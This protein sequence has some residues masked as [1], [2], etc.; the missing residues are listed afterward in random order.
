MAVIHFNYTAPE[1][2]E[3]E[4]KMSFSALS[5]GFSAGTTLGCTTA[6]SNDVNIGILNLSLKMEGG[7]GVGYGTEFKSLSVAKGKS[8]L[9][10][11][12]KLFNATKNL[13]QQ[14]QKI[15]SMISSNEIEVETAHSTDLV[16]KNSLIFTYGRDLIIENT[17][18]ELDSNKILLA[19]S[20]INMALA[21]GVVTFALA[22]NIIEESRMSKLNENLS[23]GS[24]DENT[25]GKSSGSTESVTVIVP[26]SM[27][28]FTSKNKIAY[29]ITE[30]SLNISDAKVTIYEIPKDSA[31]VSGQSS[32]NYSSE[33]KYAVFSYKLSFTVDIDDQTYACK[34]CEMTE[35]LTVDNDPDDETKLIYDFSDLTY[36][37]VNKPITVKSSAGVAKSLSGRLP[38]LMIAEE[39]ENKK[40]HLRQFSGP[41]CSHI[42][43]MIRSS[44][45]TKKFNDL[46]FILDSDTQIKDENIPGQYSLTLSSDKFVSLKIDKF[47]DTNIDASLS[48]PGFKSY[49]LNG[50]DFVLCEGAMVN[51]EER[52]SNDQKQSGKETLQIGSS[53]QFV[54]REI[55]RNELSAVSND[56]D[57]GT[58][59]KI[60]GEDNKIL[61]KYAEDDAET[62]FY[63]MQFENGVIRSSSHGMSYNLNARILVSIGYNENENDKKPYILQALIDDNQDND[64]EG[65]DADSFDKAKSKK[66]IISKNGSMAVSRATVYERAGLTYNASSLDQLLNRTFVIYANNSAKGVS[67]FEPLTYVYFFFRI[68]YDEI[69]DQLII[70][71]LPIVNYA[72]FYEAMSSVQS[73]PDLSKLVKP[74]KRT[75]LNIAMGANAA[76]PLA[77]AATIGLTSLVSAL[78]GE[79]GINYTAK[80]KSILYHVITNN[81]D[82]KKL[83]IKPVET[84]SS[85]L[86][87]IAH[88]A[89]TLISDAIEFKT[90]AENGPVMKISNNK[91]EF[92]CG[93]S[94]LKMTDAGCTVKVKDTCVKINSDGLTVTIGNAVALSLNSSRAEFSDISKKKKYTLR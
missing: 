14:G 82:N 69:Y 7:I 81:M 92:S 53:D 90:T 62:D 22:T 30:K 58:F 50:H 21:T 38:Y 67:A 91:T 76:L 83:T 57:D 42:D 32:C 10:G 15:P 51:R 11:Y 61:A 25:V 48:L 93:D 84:G 52:L 68:I 85:N 73:D 33:V 37:W 49:D 29:K 88:S 77:A 18:P 79:T 63:Q 72:A 28:F 41:I 19:V 40:L 44:L 87:E 23:E 56:D 74:G 47:D 66:S 3:Y 12:T 24:A 71:E 86:I 65:F 26:D 17:E 64:S 35:N 94:S 8:P 27:Y 54:L 5:F 4:N 31:P 39:N 46:E 36:T 80:K 43:D 1:K 55:N 16:D 20:F 70:K 78:A 6:V 34:D 59:L 45:K 89:V 60:Y 2:A 75:P 9:E 13:E